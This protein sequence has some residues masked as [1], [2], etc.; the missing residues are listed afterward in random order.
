MGAV[1]QRVVTTFNNT[2]RQ[3]KNSNAKLAFTEQDLLMYISVLWKLFWGA[4]GY[5]VNTPSKPPLQQ[6]M[7]PS[8]DRLVWKG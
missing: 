3:N 5:G 6:G 1:N 2:S 8:M 4:E 7:R